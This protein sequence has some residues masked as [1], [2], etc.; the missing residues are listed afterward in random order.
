V[1]TGL[2]FEAVTITGGLLGGV[3]AVSVRERELR[4]V[5]A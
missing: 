1:A 2:V 4:P 3:I 5:P